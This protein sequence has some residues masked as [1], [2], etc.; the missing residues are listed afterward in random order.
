MHQLPLLL[1]IKTSHAT[2]TDER[3]I[4]EDSNLCRS[5]LSSPTRFE[6]DFV[7]CKNAGLELTCLQNEHV[8]QFPVKL[9]DD[10][11]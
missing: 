9:Y 3:R 2:F 11:D 8:P 4:N 10:K 5:L 7:R 1:K 6:Y